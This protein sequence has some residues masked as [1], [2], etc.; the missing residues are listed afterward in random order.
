[1]N[2]GT[3]GVFVSG[4]DTDVGKTL[5]SAVLAL[6]WEADYWKPFQTGVATAQAD[7]NTVATL[8]GIKK[9]TNGSAGGR[10]LHPSFSVLQAP[11]APWEAARLEDTVVNL[12]GLTVPQTSAPLIVEGA[13]G[14]Y[15]P[16]NDACMMI[17]LVVMLGLPLV[18]VTRSTLGTINHTLLSLHALRARQIPVLGIVMNGPRS[19]ANREAIERFGGAPVIAEIE[20]VATLDPESIATM[21]EQIPS[22]PALLAR[23]EHRHQPT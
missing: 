14:L 23:M 11:C 10:R 7:T 18:L 15:V 1:M 9:A 4:T 13:G 21:A 6:A 5:V 3:Q 8:L 16:L 2:S 20:P 19:A 22:L 12:S 17:D